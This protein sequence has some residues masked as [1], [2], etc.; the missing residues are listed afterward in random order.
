MVAYQQHSNLRS[1]LVRTKLANRSNHRKQTG[2]RKCRK[3]CVACSRL[4]LTNFVKSRKTKER[5][6]MSNEFNC[7]TKGVV[8]MTEC[9]KCGIQY[10]GQTARNFGKRVGE[11]VNG[12]KNNK[13]TANGQHYN[14]KGHSASVS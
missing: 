1:L 5:V 9:Q 8:Y 10:V 13:D 6:E 14:S 2:M 11:H 7:K 12:I 4:K 3:G